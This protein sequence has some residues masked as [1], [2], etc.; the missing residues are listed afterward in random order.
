MFSTQLMMMNLNLKRPW[1]LSVFLMLLSIAVVLSWCLKGMDPS[2]RTLLD[3]RLLSEL[4][5][6]D[7]F[8]YGENGED[9]D[10]AV[11][12]AFAFGN[13]RSNS[14]LVPEEEAAADQQAS[15]TSMNVQP[16]T[17]EDAINELSVWRDAFSIM[18]YDPPTDNFIGFYHTR[19]KME[20][21]ANRKLWHSMTSFSYILRHLFPERFNPSM[22]ELALAIGSGDF[23]HVWRWSLPRLD[24]VAPVL[25]FGSAF[26]HTAVYGNMIAMPM[27]VKSHLD[28]FSNWVQNDG[29][30]VCKELRASRSDGGDLVFGKEY[31]LEWDTLIVGTACYS[32]TV[33]YLGLDTSNLFNQFFFFRTMTQPQVVWRGSDFDY[34]SILESRGTLVRPDMNFAVRG[35][36][37][38][39]GDEDQH[40]IDVVN[41]LM[42]EF[43]TLLPRWKCAVL[44]AE[45]ELQVSLQDDENLPWANMKFSTYPN[46]GGK[47]PTHGSSKYSAW[48]SVGIAVGESMSLPDLARYKYHI[49]LGGG[50]GTTWTG[51]IDK[52][53]MPG[54]LFHHLTPTKD[55]FHDLLVPWRHYIP[56][57]EDL[58]DLKSKYDWAESHPNEAKRIADASTQFMRELGTVEGFGRM[59]EEDFVVPLREV[60][61]AYVPLSSTYTD[62]IS[63]M[64]TN[65]ARIIPVVTCSGHGDACE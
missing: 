27:P 38:D 64:N 48:E 32:L 45:A 15:T 6:D 28:C 58:S 5:G 65:H 7:D 3:G 61:D 46:A 59:F 18:I 13:S 1:R 21:P 44:T 35:S 40:R 8:N 17:L 10:L 12:L 30:R 2:T 39:I 51:T 37:G 63:W 47:S 19:N 52:L 26:R 34:L 54:L 57:S 55:Y 36:H 42:A 56:V 60:I 50:G 16:F 29:G 53:A 20:H 33:V 9:Y 11:E 31:E 25:M 4:L 23:P 14:E 43:D 49:D 62:M 24:G 41:A 22:P